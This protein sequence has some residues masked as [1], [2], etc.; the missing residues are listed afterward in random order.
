MNRIIFI[1]LLGMSVAFG[2]DNEIA[3]PKYN[4][5]S[6]TQVPW[7][8][9]DDGDG[10]QIQKVDI[11]GAAVTLDPTNLATGA[12]QDTGNTT[13]SDILAKIIAA[14]ATEAKQD[15]AQTALDS[16][17]ASLAG[18]SFAN[19]TTNATTVVKASAGVVHALA[20]NTGGT[21]S[22][23]A[24]WDG[25]PV[26]AGTLIATV[27]TTGAGTTVIYDAAFSTSL[28]VVTAGA[29]AADITAIYR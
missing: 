1:L 29:V 12:K 11:M 17:A 8:S 10:N 9:I 22:T 26:G 13:L 28:T 2:A 20:I 14:P 3:G 6:E 18:N 4:S 24:I 27:A 15:T 16:I 23:A 7:A 19:I 25:D 21:T 5:G